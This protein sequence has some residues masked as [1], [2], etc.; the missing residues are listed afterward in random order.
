MQRTKLIK[1]AAAGLMAVLLAGCSSTPDSVEDPLSFDVDAQLPFVTAAPEAV[2]TASPSPAPTT[3]LDTTAPTQDW[4]NDHSA[5]LGNTDTQTEEGDLVN[6]TTV[7]YKQLSTGDS[8]DDVQKLQQ[9]LKDLKYYTGAVDG[10]YGSALT[11]AV[12]RFQ[13]TLGLDTTGIAT[14]NLQRMIYSSAAPTYTGNSYTDTGDTTSFD[15]TDDQNYDATP[16]KKPSTSSSDSSNDESDTGYTTLS[17]G[18]SGTK[19][20]NLQSS[21]KTL[22]YYSGAVDGVY[23]SGTVAAVKRFEQAYGKTQTGIATVALQTK[24]FSGDAKPYTQ[25][26]PAPAQGTSSYVTLKP[27]DTG[28]RVKQLQQRLKELGYFTA[29]VGGNYLTETSKAVKAFQDALGLDT[30]GIATA[31]LQRKLFASSAPANTTNSGSY[32]KLQKNDTGAWVTALQ[33][34]LKELGYFK[35]SVDG[36]YGSGTVSAVKLFETAY[37]KTP[38]GIATVALQKTLYSD[39]AKPYEK[40]TPTPEAEYIELSQ[41]DKGLRVMALQ[42]RLM[43]LGYFS[44]DVD[45]NYGSSTVKAIKL[46]EQAYGKTPTGVATVALQKT[47]FSDSAKPYSGATA[48]PAPTPAAEYVELRPGDTGSQVK[49]LQ[50]RL[51]ELGYFDG[52]IGGNY[53]EKTTK[54]VKL[55][56]RAYGK[57]ET[58]IATVS[59]QKTLFSDSAKPYSGASATPAPEYVKLSPGDSGDRVKQLQTRLKELGY[60]TGS[61]G[62]NY[63]ELTTAAVKRFQKKIGANQTGVATVTLQQKLFADDAPAYKSSETPSPYTT[64]KLGSTGDAVTALQNRLIELGYLSEDDVSL[65]DFEKSTRDAVIDAQLARSYESDG[66]AD[67]DFQEYIFSDEAY[68]YIDQSESDTAG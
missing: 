42:N 49:K 41:G 24:L 3:A 26:T 51:K 54:A 43:D 7:V 29:S 38:T 10:R 8:G 61:I 59:L 28:D 5:D 64:L 27:G 40:P 63:G 50:T 68:D 21:L 20:R 15:Q 9:R 11:T 66:T 46:F 12:K 37:G 4:Q 33:N 48:T 22:G 44:G 67:P 13:S 55:F 25:A 60:F 19:V 31:S 53:L 16:T 45:G 18:D 17:Y 35:G 52:D 30:T 1:W 2:A 34:R 23:G 58:G 62:G 57:D 36:V 14:A 56:Q 65:G 39:S 6:D 47:L 32:V